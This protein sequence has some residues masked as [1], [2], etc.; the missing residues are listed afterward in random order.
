LVPVY[1]RLATDGPGRQT[2]HSMCL[3]SVGQMAAHDAKHRRLQQLRRR[4]LEERF[5]GS[6]ESENLRI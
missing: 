3:L 4:M 5:Y 6:W 2:A 1:H